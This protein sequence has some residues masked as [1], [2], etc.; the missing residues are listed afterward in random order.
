ML[1]TDDDLRLVL[2]S[3]T[4][5]VGEALREALARRHGLARTGRKAAT[6]RKTSAPKPKKRARRATAGAKKKSP[7]R[8]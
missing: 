5:A 1:L 2:D 4:K 6:K 7:R 8:V 3:F